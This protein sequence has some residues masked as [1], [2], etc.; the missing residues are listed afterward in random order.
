ML[1]LKMKFV[2][3]IG[4][5]YNFEASGHQAAEKVRDVDTSANTKVFE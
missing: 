5:W 1:P 2:S 4:S 3:E